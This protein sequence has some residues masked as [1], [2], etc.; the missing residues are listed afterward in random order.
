MYCRILN[1]Q[2]CVYSS[3]KGYCFLARDQCPM[4]GGILAVG[5]ETQ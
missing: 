2:Y 3:Y 4:S 5:F 1:L